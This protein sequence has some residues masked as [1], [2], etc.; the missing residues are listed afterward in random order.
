VRHTLDPKVLP[1]RAYFPARWRS[2]GVRPAFGRRWVG[3][4]GVFDVFDVRTAFG[5]RLAGG[6]PA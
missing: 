1:G 3:V 6:L 4:L 2:V 5:R